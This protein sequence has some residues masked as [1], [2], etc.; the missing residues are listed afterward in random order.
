ME[1]EQL[2]RETDEVV[3]R[4]M[5][6]SEMANVIMIVMGAVALVMIIMIW[7]MRVREHR[8]RMEELRQQREWEEYQM[9][10]RGDRYQRM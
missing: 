4:A 1:Y 5:R 10:L 3:R 9:A 7:A 8:A 2:V 6:H